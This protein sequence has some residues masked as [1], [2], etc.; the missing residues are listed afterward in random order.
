MGIEEVE[1]RKTYLIEATPAGEKISESL[2]F[3]IDLGFLLRRDTK[4]ADD[5]GGYRVETQYYD[6][7]REVGGIKVAFGKRIVQ[8]K[9]VIIFKDSEV[10]NN[11]AMDDAI[12]KPPAKVQID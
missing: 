12:F 3:D 1:G 2:F 9:I 10:K 4:V 5:N 8:D 7:Y 11:L 6:D